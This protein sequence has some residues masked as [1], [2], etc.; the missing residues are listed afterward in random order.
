M[1]DT[2][3]VQA[4]NIEHTLFLLEV[5]FLEKLVLKGTHS[6]ENGNSGEREYLFKLNTN[7]PCDF[8][9]YHFILCTSPR[10]ILMNYI[11]NPT[12]PFLF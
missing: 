11:L 4:P 7:H 1:P 12:A 5:T 2:L 6:L 10:A 8:I 3:R 9:G